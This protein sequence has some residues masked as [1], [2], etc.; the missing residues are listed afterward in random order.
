MNDVN[1][2]WSY[3][4][5][6]FIYNPKINQFENLKKELSKNNISKYN[7]LV[8]KEVR[9]YKNLLKEAN[10]NLKY[11]Q[12]KI[13]MDIF[14]LNQNNLKNDDSLQ[15]SI[16]D[17]FQFCNMIVKNNIN[18][19]NI[20]EMISNSFSNFEELKEH[21]NVISKIDN[22]NLYDKIKEETLEKIFLFH[23][24]KELIQ[25]LDT[26]QKF[27]KIFPNN[28]NF[29]IECDKLR[30]LLNHKNLISQYK[31]IKI[32]L[33]K[34]DKNLFIEK[35][36]YEIILNEL[37]LKEELIEFLKEK[38]ENDIINLQ[39]L[40]DPSQS[41]IITINDINE[42]TDIIVL[43]DKLYSISQSENIICD[44]SN[45]IKEI[46]ESEKLLK[47]IINLTE[48]SDE[49]LDLFNRKL[50]KNAFAEQKFDLISKNGK[51]E[52]LFKQNEG[53]SIYKKKEEY[54]C[55]VITIINEENKEK[56]YEDE[57]EDIV[58]FKD[59]LMLIKKEQ[60]KKKEIVKRIMLLIDNVVKIIKILET[61]IH[62]GFDEDIFYH[63]I[64]KIERE[65]LNNNFKILESC[66]I[67]S[68]NNEIIKKIEKKENGV[69]MLL[70]YLEEIESEQNRKE[71]EI[72][73]KNP[74]L[75]LIFGRQFNKIIYFVQLVNFVLNI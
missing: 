59:L 48:K 31:E 36:K 55:K 60:L 42:L 8:Q 15:K 28:N 11:K 3:L 52:I 6:F 53:Y 26:F 69:Q 20:I 13:F 58:K 24:K 49:L 7:E 32:L 1:L 66:I 56:Q 9:E 17:Y 61:I 25:F 39:Q 35:Q 16:K 18:D 14:H 38:N 71:K 57:F 43:K 29:V 72:Y 5:L 22:L 34:W 63:F 37:F 73:E 40:I 19:N 46:K 62:K 23:R 30:K 33:N 50:N 10:D 21:L 44:L 4:K 64:I 2:I 65:D 70:K 12:S 47:K 41:N 67:Y 27:H 54:K 75:R 51:F 68:K 74:N 45:I